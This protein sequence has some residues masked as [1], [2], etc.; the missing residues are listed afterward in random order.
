MSLSIDII[1]NNIKII[2]SWKPNR[3][4]KLN[5]GFTFYVDTPS[6]YREK[7]TVIEQTDDYYV[8][9]TNSKLKK[10]Q[11]IDSVPENELI[12][13]IDKLRTNKLSDSD[14]DDL[15]WKWRKESTYN[16]FKEDF[17]NLYD[18]LISNGKCG[19]HWVPKGR[20]IFNYAQNK[21]SELV[22]KYLKI[23]TLQ[24]AGKASIVT[25]NNLDNWWIKIAAAAYQ[26]DHGHGLL[27]VNINT[28]DVFLDCW[29]LKILTKQEKPLATIRDIQDFIGGSDKT[30]ADELSKD[31]ASHIYDFMFDGYVLLVVNFGWDKVREFVNR[32]GNGPS[33]NPH[34]FTDMM[35]FY[36]ILY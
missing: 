26:A 21:Y 12:E 16:F 36:D 2:S 20:I 33:W 1:R 25:I 15:I 9:L 31:L 28:L 23:G 24:S 11:H 7:V 5:K 35:Q 13:I 8:Q 10:E 29:S 17:A 22:D 34:E 4:T 14:I 3:F 27:V 19:F 30:I 18:Y 6:G 32:K